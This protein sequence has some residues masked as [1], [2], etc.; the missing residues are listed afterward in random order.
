M[1][2]RCWN[3][4]FHTLLELSLKTIIGIVSAAHAAID[5]KYL[6]HCHLLMESFRDNLHHP[7][8]LK[9]NMVEKIS[10]SGLSFDDLK[11]G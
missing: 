1:Y 7:Q 3:I 5:V 6:D 9:K 10:S 2:L 8:Y 4:T 11:M